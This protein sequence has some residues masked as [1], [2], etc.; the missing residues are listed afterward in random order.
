MARALRDYARHN[1]QAVRI[2]TVTEKARLSPLNY[3]EAN[4]NIASDI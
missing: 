4:K 2:F 1:P 3:R